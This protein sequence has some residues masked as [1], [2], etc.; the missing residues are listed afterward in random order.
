MKIDFILFKSKLKRP[1]PLFAA[2]IWCANHRPQR[3][4]PT[5]GKVQSQ[6]SLSINDYW[7]LNITI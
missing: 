4:P 2:R 3:H 7:T 1:L 6:L 5:I